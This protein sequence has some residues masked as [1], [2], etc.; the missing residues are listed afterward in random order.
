MVTMRTLLEKATRYCTSDGS[1]V[2]N[3]RDSVGSAV[4]AYVSVLLLLPLLAAAEEPKD[5]PGKPIEKVSLDRPADFRTDILPILQA[6]CLACHAGEDA[7]AEIDLATPA[8]MIRS[9]AV[10]A[11]QADKSLLLRSAAHQRRR[12]MPPDQNKVGA[13]ALTSRELGLLQLWI[14]EGAKESQG[15]SNE[16]ICWKILPTR[17]V[18]IYALALSDDGQWAA[19]GR[20]ASIH[21][22]HV[23][24]Q[25]LV[26]SLVDSKLSSAPGTAHRD[27]VHALA[28]SADGQ[29][30]AS[31]GHRDIKL[32][33]RTVAEEGKAWEWKLARVIEPA[34]DDTGPVDRVLAL[35]FSPDA[36]ELASAGG[37]PGRSGELLL[38]RVAD[39]SLVREFRGAHKDA[40]YDIKFAPD[41]RSLASAS[42]DR[43][44]KVFD[45]ATGKCTHVLEG[46]AGYVLSL[47]WK[48]DGKKL[49]TGGADMVVNVWNLDAVQQGLGEKERV[50]TT[51]AREAVV[52][53]C[54]LG[55]SDDLVASSD[56]LEGNT[57]PLHA[58]AASRDGAVVLA[59]GQEGVLWLR[60]G[61]ASAKNPKL[62]VTRLTPPDGAAPD[63]D[64]P[65]SKP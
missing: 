3:V 22:Y 47:A 57:Q 49:A 45:L 46:H 28:M 9:Q 37:L 63:K 44:A 21:I 31:G 30:L 24:T 50:K 10:V 36:R 18:P 33:N 12:I 11:G 62:T 60:R 7:K 40:V 61:V 35:A 6:N 20:G 65:A 26:A 38:W 14:N 27:T 56:T 54:F 58:V 4:P 39:G 29:W 8:A 51:V 5:K 42:A 55:D 23:P 53:L 17:W 32:W 19:C 15:A 25:R 43:F 41:A 64:T 2:S 59:G 52:A 16:A 48:R 1:V 13:R 34:R